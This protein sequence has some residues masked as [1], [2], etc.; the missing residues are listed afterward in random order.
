MSCFILT[1]LHIAT[2]ARYAYRIR[3]NERTNS[4]DKDTGDSFREMTKRLDEALNNKYAPEKKHS[5]YAI[6][7]SIAQPLQYPQYGDSYKTAEEKEITALNTLASWL[8][9]SNIVSYAE[10]YD[11]DID[12][13]RVIRDRLPEI[14]SLSRDP[15]IEVDDASVYNMVWCCEYQ[16]C[17]YDGW[18]QSPAYKI[19]AAIKEKAADEMAEALNPEITWSRQ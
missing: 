6:A 16:S 13:H 1:D 7:W 19:C 9:F 3:W 12:I 4:F 5:F 18:K 8:L 2:L 14:V 17:E 11:E 10:R 15:K